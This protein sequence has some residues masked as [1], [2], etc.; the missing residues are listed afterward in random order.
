MSEYTYIHS[1][2]MY[3]HTHTPPYIYIIIKLQT[4]LDMDIIV[5]FIVLGQ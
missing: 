4:V 2:Y 1:L 3:I 5:P